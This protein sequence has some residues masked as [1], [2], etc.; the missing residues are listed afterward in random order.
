[1][2][3]VDMHMPGL[4]GPQLVALWRSQQSTH[5]PIIMLTADARDEAQH[6]CLDAGADSFLTK[7][8]GKRQLIEEVARL[9][10]PASDPPQP[11]SKPLQAVLDANV[12]DELRQLG[13]PA[14]IR[15]LITNFIAE[16][17]ETLPRIAR[18]LAGGD[19][20]QWHEQ[21]HRLKGSACDVG[22][23]RLAASCAAA[24]GI[25]PGETDAQNR[26]D[27]VRASLAEALTALTRHLDSKPSDH[28]A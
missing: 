8:V 17:E 25:R 23:L 19:P 14:L 15:D 1:L 2:A 6:A 21:L 9:A 28:H 5:L 12:L 27:V 18:A 24:E 10:R 26:L 22:A 7:P 11:D 16:S 3:I 13:G 4:S 20:G